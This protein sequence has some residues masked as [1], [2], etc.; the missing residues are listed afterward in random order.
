M[1]G[2]YRWESYLGEDGFTGRLLIITVYSKSRN[3]PYPF[4]V[5]DVY[6]P[7]GMDS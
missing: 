3:V 4:N 5:Y 6:A 7:P 1:P 2:E